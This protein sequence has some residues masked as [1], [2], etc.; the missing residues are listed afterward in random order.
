MSDLDNLLKQLGQIGSPM[1]DPEEDLQET[2]ERTKDLDAMLNQLK[3]TPTPKPEK[4]LITSA[5]IPKPTLS[6]PDDFKQYRPSKF[7]FLPTKF[8]SHYFGYT[9]AIRRLNSFLPEAEKLA[10]QEDGDNSEDNETLKDSVVSKD[11]TLI[12]FEH[13]IENTRHK[14]I[15]EK[16]EYKP[17][18]FSVFNSTDTIYNE[19]EYTTLQKCVEELDAFSTLQLPEGEY[20]LDSTSLQIK[21]PLCIKGIG[22]KVIIRSGSTS[23]VLDIIAPESTFENIRFISNESNDEPSIRIMMNGLTK[24]SKCKFI[25]GQKQ[26][27]A[28][29]GKGYIEFS[30]CTIKN[31]NNAGMNMNGNMTVVC[32]NCKV[33]NTGFGI[34]CQKFVKMTL[35]NCQLIDN[36]KNG[37]SIYDNANVTVCG[38]NF[39]GNKIM[40]ME[41]LSHGE[42][43]YFEGNTFENNGAAAGLINDHS[44]VT[45]FNNT[46][47]DHIKTGLEVKGQSRLI[48][49]GN[50]FSDV[51]ENALILLS[52]KSVAYSENDKYFGKC[53]V[54]IAVIGGSYFIGKSNKFTDLATCG[55]L[56]NDCGRIDLTSCEFSNNDCP[57]IQASSK[58]E[59]T[60]RDS[61]FSNTNQSF[62]T[63]GLGVFGKVTN[64]TFDQARCCVEIM[65]GIKDFLFEDCTFSNA[66]VSCVRIVGGTAPSFTNC[67]F[68]ESKFGM[69]CI[70]GC[71]PTFNYCDFERDD[72]GCAVSGEETD[73]TFIGCYFTYNNNYSLDISQA[74]AKLIGCKIKENKQLGFSA[75]KSSIVDL[76]DCTLSANEDNGAQIG[77]NSNVAMTN[78]TISDH[79]S[80]NGLFVDNSTLKCDDC[81][82][83]NNHETHIKSRSN[84]KIN[85]NGCEF[86]ETEKGVA[87][88]F[89]DNSDVLIKDSKISD[90]KEVG[91][92]SINSAS[93]TIEKTTVRNG[94]IMGICMQK[95]SNFT[96]NECDISNIEKTGIYIDNSNGR[97]KDCIIGNCGDYAIDII[98]GKV[99]ESGCR[100]SNNGRGDLHK[101]ES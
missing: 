89:I 31:G 42:N 28:S 17:H 50:S 14:I 38:C 56:I 45:F 101:N 35:N 51:Q 26:I 19:S 2:T 39:K 46:V 80:K 12:D 58:S 8:A 92:I 47:K 68:K 25:G 18:R 73:A 81:Y 97:I 78:C 60:I 4:T 65:Q 7:K 62:M 63:F 15:G 3:S 1:G 86:L 10:A 24:F 90:Q 6:I 21:K 53:K 23:C 43:I 41:I 84:S 77:L 37:L 40:G 11:P 64:C 54:G 74:K 83:S 59:I 88:Q 13:I 55:I 48:M 85:I 66:E 57:S 96:I 30:D 91:I 34:L 61:D 100:Y 79:E 67:T 22:D 5:E 27:I 36:T 82:F 75:L 93:I 94:E 70:N 9:G 20:T 32:T 49:S 99:E 44:R 87:M 95:G 33:K 16:L 98:G 52:D 76:I 71:A 69:Q 72:N 29:D